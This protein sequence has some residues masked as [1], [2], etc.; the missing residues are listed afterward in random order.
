VKKAASIVLLWSL[1]SYLF[2]IGSLLSLLLTPAVAEAQAAPTITV[3]TTQTSPGVSFGVHVRDASG[4]ETI[5]A[6][7]VP[8]P[9]NMQALASL[10][11]NGQT[12]ADFIASAGVPEVVIFRL[13]AGAP[14]TSELLAESPRVL[15]RAGDGEHVTHGTL[16]VALPGI[17]WESRSEAL[18]HRRLAI[19][20]RSVTGGCQPSL[21]LDQGIVAQG[22]VVTCGSAQPLTLTVAM[23]GA[24]GPE[25]DQ[26]QI[27]AAELATHVIVPKLT[28]A[29]N[30]EWQTLD[31]RIQAWHN[32][33]PSDPAESLR[34]IMSLTG[35][36]Y[37]ALVDG[38]AGDAAVALGIAEYTWQLPVLVATHTPGESAVID[39]FRM[40]VAPI[41]SDGDPDASARW[42][43]AVGMFSSEMEAG[44]IEKALGV[45][46]VSTT[47][48]LAAASD[49][50]IELVQVT[51]D[52]IDAE[53]PRLTGL[54][55]TIIAAL[56]NEVRTLKRNAVVPIQPV[57]ILPGQQEVAVWSLDPNTGIG[58]YLI[59]AQLLNG[60]ATAPIPAAPTTGVPGAISLF[61][62]AMGLAVAAET[63]ELTA[64]AAAEVARA[65]IN[66]IA[67]QPR[68][69][70]TV[71]SGVIT[72]TFGA[73]PLAAIAVTLGG[74]TVYI[75]YRCTTGAPV[76]LVCPGP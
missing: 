34:E 46:A 73:A 41:A 24:A 60:G 21:W 38:Y 23:D 30:I 42:H 20:Y 36:A 8:Q 9:A 12:N 1:S 51:P 55:Q 40:A 27:R 32:N 22:S 6:H 70:M 58:L 25:T 62:G 59:G 61:A 3:D 65:G 11:M 49:Q 44:A 14:G 35:E 72:L 66:L 19:T 48:V 4:T 16:I 56:T 64:A 33:P 47:R 45:Q 57:P 50:A 75:V 18:T 68:T 54:P 76:P 74:A 69:F 52:N 13:W 29:T 71:G 28:L 67:T 5:G 26:K 17:S 15:I 39:A 63:I 10:P 43:S 37:Y 2:P 7:L 31:A 53:L